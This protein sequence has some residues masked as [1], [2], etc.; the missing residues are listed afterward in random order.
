MEKAVSSPRELEVSVLGNDEP[1]ASCA[2]EIVPEREFYDYTA[3][4][5]DENTGLIAPAELSDE[6]T[7]R[8]GELAV[9]A[10]KALDCSGMG[11][12]DFLMNRE[13]EDLFISEINTI[14]GFTQIS[15]YP[16]LWEL[17]GI[18]YKELITSLIELSIQR[19]RSQKSLK[20]D[21]TDIQKT[22]EA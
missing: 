13:T 20:V 10:F 8:L 17:S 21:I 15:M 19:N 3:K 2:G 7:S 11:R 6:L 4:Y 18:P 16:K 22:P 5:L 9:G 1:R 14:P 12:V